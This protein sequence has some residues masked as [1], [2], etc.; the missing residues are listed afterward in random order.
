MNATGAVFNA[1]RRWG[2]AKGGVGKISQLSLSEVVRSV[3]DTRRLELLRV[4]V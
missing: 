3:K 1:K 4:E 2:K